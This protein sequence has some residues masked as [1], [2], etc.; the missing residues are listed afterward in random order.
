MPENPRLLS[1]G[2]KG[3]T[4]RSQLIAYK[5]FKPELQFTSVPGSGKVE[6]QFLVEGSGPI[7]RPSGKNIFF[8]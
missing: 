7:T 8:I 3:I 6:Y 2:I 4:E 5:K 1:P